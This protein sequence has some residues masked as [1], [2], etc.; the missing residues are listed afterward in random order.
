MW[1]RAT[2][3][4]NWLPQ[5][6]FIKVI[7]TVRIRRTGGSEIHERVAQ[8]FVVVHSLILIPLRRIFCFSF[9]TSHEIQN[10]CASD[11]VV[12]TLVAMQV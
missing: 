4:E 11:A 12:A 1:P 8:L 2:N 5:S 9:C 3:P 7:S 10:F 6:Q